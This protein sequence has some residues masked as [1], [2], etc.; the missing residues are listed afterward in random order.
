MYTIGMSNRSESLKY[1]GITGVGIGL[2]ANRVTNEQL[3]HDFNIPMPMSGPG[4][5]EKRTGIE[6]R[7]IA[8]PLETTT[9]L[10]IKA[11]KGAIQQAG[12][13]PDQVDSIVVA[14]MSSGVSCPNTAS[15]VQSA[16]RA[17]HNVSALDINAA[18][19]GFVLGLQKEIAWRLSRKGPEVSTF[20]GVDIMSRVVDM[21]SPS[22]I[23]FGDGAGAVTIQNA[24][25][26]EPFFQTRTDGSRGGLITLESLSA[27]T[28][29][30]E[31]VAIEARQSFQMKGLLVYE[32]GITDIPDFFREFMRSAGLKIDDI[33]KVVFHQANGKMLETIARKAHIPTEKVISTVAEYGNTSSA[34]IPMAFYD[35]FKK[36]N[37][38]YGDRVV[39]VGFGGGLI[40]GAGYMQIVKPNPVNRL[41]VRRTLFRWGQRLKRH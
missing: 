10:A 24:S 13:R 27:R 18:C 37:L 7:F 12:I 2:P 26:I 11:A 32:W 29:M 38:K 40:W 23:L 5:I 36:G 35:A 25:A 16:V 9:S 33:D 20:I 6:S 17:S 28:P 30:I 19:S 21:T 41:P 8:G 15:Q 1:P 3:V 31:D 14:S 4:A 22:G 34:S 39:M